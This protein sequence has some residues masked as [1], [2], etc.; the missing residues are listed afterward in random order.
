[1]LTYLFCIRYELIRN[2][3]QMIYLYLQNTNLP[4]AQNE[5]KVLVPSLKQCPG[6]H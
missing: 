5:S 3:R 2:L 4:D 1:M 6:G